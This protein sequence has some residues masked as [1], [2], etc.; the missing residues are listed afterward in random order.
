M[1]QHVRPAIEAAKVAGKLN[2][3]AKCATAKQSARK[4]TDTKKRGRPKKPESPPLPPAVLTIPQ[5]CEIHDMS[6]A[7]YHKLR[8]AGKGPREM[9]ATVPEDET[10]VNKGKRKS[11]YVRITLEA[12]ADWRREREQASTAARESVEASS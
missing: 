11:G 6:P 9:R 4:A 3:K 2:R 1:R 10:R 12:A 7:Y 5:F 8:A